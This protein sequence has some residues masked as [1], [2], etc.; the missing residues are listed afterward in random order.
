MNLRN[1]ELKRWDRLEPEKRVSL[2]RKLAAQLPETFRLQ[3]I[4]SY[5]LGGQRHSV[6][7]F[8]YKG[9]SFSLIPGGEAVLGYD[10]NH[11]FKPTPKQLASWEDTREEYGIRSSLNVFIRKFSTPVRTIRIEPFLLEVNA[12][13]AGIE[14]IEIDGEEFPVENPAFGHSH[15]QV[16]DRVAREGFRLPTSDEWEYACRAGS[17]TLFRW[18]DSCPVDCYPT[19]TGEQIEFDLHTRPNAFGL[20]IAEDPYNWEF[21]AEPKTSRGGDG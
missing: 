9:S 15:Q 12:R 20:H 2:A 10:P 14:T 5:K 1:F 7:L 13:E 6:A 16:V 19:D 8:T 21:V 18:G 17:R 4:R 11:P 3:I